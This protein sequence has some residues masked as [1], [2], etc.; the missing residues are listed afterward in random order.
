MFSFGGY[1]SCGAD[2]LDKVYV[3]C[4]Q[5]SGQVE[6]AIN[7]LGNLEKR[8]EETRE[9]ENWRIGNW[10]SWIGEIILR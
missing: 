1:W 10:R 7:L 6:R 8:R 4:G 3:D 2:M 5:A 9:L